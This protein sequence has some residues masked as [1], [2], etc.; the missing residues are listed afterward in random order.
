M[1][2]SIPL[3]MHCIKVVIMKLAN[4]LLK[5]CSIL[6]QMDVCHFRR[7][8]TC[9]HPLRLLPLLL[10]LLLMLLRRLN[11]SLGALDLLGE[12]IDLILHLG[13]LFGAVLPNEFDEFFVLSF[14]P[15]ALLDGRLLVLVELVLTLRIVSAWDEA[16]NLN[17]VILVQLLGSDALTSA[18]LLDCPLKQVRFIVCPILF[19]VISLF[20]LQLC[21][22][23]KDFRSGIVCD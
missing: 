5:L 13:P 11:L 9:S 14:D 17:P 23:V 8:K 19:S 4:E 15:I 6:V 18:V 22:F 16:C 10:G 1:L 2:M 21:Q 3:Q 12:P 7:S 20:S